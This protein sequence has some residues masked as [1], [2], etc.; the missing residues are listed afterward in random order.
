MRTLIGLSVAL[1]GCGTSSS[2]DGP[3]ADASVVLPD[4][5]EVARDAAQPAAS[6]RD[7]YN[8]LFPSTTNARCDFCHAMPASQTSNGK[9]S[10]GATP[11]QAYQALVGKDST[12]S[13]CSGMPLV[14]PGDPE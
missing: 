12:S 6:F 3:S 13:L 9:L 7:I 1:L 10:F 4:A 14:T 8:E 11:E 2:A 5:G